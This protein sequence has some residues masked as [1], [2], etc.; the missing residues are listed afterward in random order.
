MIIDADETQIDGR[1]AAEISLHILAAERHGP[2]AHVAARYGP[3]QQVK[4]TG[5]RLR[6]QWRRD[7]D[8]VLHHA[9]PIEIEEQVRVISR[10]LIR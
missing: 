2:E 1:I 8:L 6:V 9:L 5:R 4:F 3:A 10:A 7:I